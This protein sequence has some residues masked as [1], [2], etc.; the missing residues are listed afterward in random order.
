MR[1][2][3]SLLAV[4]I[5]LAMGFGHAFGQTLFEKL[6]MPGPLAMAHA[7]LEEKCSNCHDSFAQKAQS[8]LCASCHKPVQADRTQKTGFHGRNSA[9]RTQDCRICHSDHKGRDA[10]IMLLDR[11]T[12][13]HDLTDFLLKGPH[14]AVPCASCHASGK[15]M[16]DATSACIGCHKKDE[17][18][19]GRLGTTCEGCHSAEAWL[20]AK[21]FDHTKTKFHLNGAHRGVPCT[22][23][24][25]NEQWKGVGTQCVDCHRLA[26]KHSGKNGLKCAD[27]HTV[28]K[29]SAVKFNHDKQ[30]RF[31]LRGAHAKVV[32]TGCHAA[33]L[34]APVPSTC[35]GCHKEQDPHK[36]SL[37]QACQQCHGEE[38]WAK[39]VAFDH[40][41]SRFPLIGLH[42]AVPCESC[43]LSQNYK[44]VSS[45]C[46]DCHKDTHHE[47]LLGTK[48]AACHNPNGWTLWRF[49]HAQA[50]SFPL[51]GRH[52]GLACAACH[53][54]SHPQNLKISKECFSCHAADDA[55]RGAFGRAC[56]SCHSTASFSERIERK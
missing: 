10:D 16:R 13:Q 32:C 26:D 47:G 24:H 20:P 56:G 25:T 42:A 49:D 43:H 5:V 37:G 2:P 33:D 3:T 34:H 53:T 23:C 52:V 31:P 51:T 48:C 4:T 28:D 21:S 29:W 38:S 22:T 15:A 14:A 50:T 12:F 8:N 9:A 7:K 27:C 30:T 11:E 44:G 17:P 19:Q 55:H 45:S 41:L 39:K 1:L 35:S 54:T 46:S 18:H 40:D 6:V 36:G